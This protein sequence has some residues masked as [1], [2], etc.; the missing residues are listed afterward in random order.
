MFL[1]KGMFL[2]HR[3]QFSLHEPM[4]RMTRMTFMIRMI[5]M[6]L[7]T[8]LTLIVLMTIMTPKALS[9][10]CALSHGVQKLCSRVSYHPRQR[11]TPGHRPTPGAPIPFHG[12][13]DP[14]DS[15]WPFYD[16]SLSSHLRVAP[17]PMLSYHLMVSPLG[18][19]SSTGGAP[20]I[21][22]VLTS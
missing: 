11:P 15:P 16:L 5:R 12:P 10:R 19:V 3:L 13:H 2:L 20:C 21:C 1:R 4:I 18:V 22:S 17:R 14:P 7:M 8:F 9:Q 6:I